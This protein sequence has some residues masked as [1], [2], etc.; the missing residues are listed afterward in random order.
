[1]ELKCNK[2]CAIGSPHSDFHMGGSAFKRDLTESLTANAKKHYKWFFQ[3]YFRQRQ[4]LC[5]SF[6]FPT[7]FVT[8]SVMLFCLNSPIIHPW[9]RANT[10][11]LG[12]LL[13]ALIQASID[14][15]KRTSGI[16]CFLSN[17][18]VPGMHLKSLPSYC[19][20]VA[21][22]WFLTGSWCF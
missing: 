7:H 22:Q 18:A 21:A 14:F 19:L 5:H 9:L 10:W 8:Y 2:L 20:C 6:M 13:H 3:D 17:T 1:M 4:A 11:T 15:A 16:A 12:L